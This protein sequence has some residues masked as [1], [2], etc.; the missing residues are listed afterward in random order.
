MQLSLIESSPV[1][2]GYD[3]SVSLK[4]VESKG[5]YDSGL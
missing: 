4:L 3:E 2:F 5:G 1:T